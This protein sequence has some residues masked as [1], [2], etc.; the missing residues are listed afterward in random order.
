MPAGNYK[1]PPIQE[2]LCEF[3][4][5]PG[6]E[7]DI[8]IPGKL[9]SLIE[10]EYSGKPRQQIVPTVATQPDG[11]PTLIQNFRVQ[12]PD[13][14]GTRLISVGKDTLTVSVLKPYEGWTRFKPRIERA[15][16]AYRKVAEPKNITRI[17]VRY[18]NRI[19][20]DSKGAGASTYFVNELDEDRSLGARVTSFMRRYEYV[21]KGDEKLL[22]TNA[23]I[24][25]QNPEA[26]TEFI[27]DI[28]T[29]WDKEPLDFERALE[30]TDALHSCEG[31]A[32]E[33]MITD[34]ARK[35]FDV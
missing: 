25:P 21:T 9:H 11:Q 19:I 33:A 17:G 6:R 32:F 27:V 23:N 13:A 7:W 31:K 35:L 10:K 22:I 1:N 26:T 28:D 15:L 16:A 29:I 2:A 3:Q 20:V 18:I 4:F 14:D 34:T 5:T 12:L 24:V 8:T 30:K